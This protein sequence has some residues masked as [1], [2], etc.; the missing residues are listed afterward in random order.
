MQYQPSLFSGSPRSCFCASHINKGVE[1]GASQETQCS[2]AIC[3]S[4]SLSR[5][6]RRRLPSHLQ[7]SQL[8]AHSLLHCSPSTTTHQLQ[9]RHNLNLSL[10]IPSLLRVFYVFLV[11]TLMNFLVVQGEVYPLKLTAPNTIPTNDTAD[12]HPL[13]QAAS[14]SRLLSS[15]IAQLSSIAAS[16]IFAADSCARCQT[17]LEVAKFISLATPSNGPAFL[18]EMCTI[19]KLASNCAVMYG[20]DSGLGSVLTQVLANADVGGYDGQVNIGIHRGR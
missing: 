11:S 5:A 3:S 20:L 16:P 1:L 10:A 12:P 4:S 8:P 14:S 15:A 19:F 13:P 7:R 18:V 17:F 2:R 6:S 9:R